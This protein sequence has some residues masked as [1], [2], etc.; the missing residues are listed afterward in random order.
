MDSPDILATLGVHYTWWSQGKRKNTPQHK[1]LKRWANMDQ[2]DRGHGQRSI[3]KAYIEY[4]VTH[5][6]VTLIQWRPTSTRRTLHM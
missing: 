6:I 4:R 2:K 5:R 3:I 1:N